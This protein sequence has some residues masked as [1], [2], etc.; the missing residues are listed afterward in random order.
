MVSTN[1]NNKFNKK[2]QDEVLKLTDEDL[3]GLPDLD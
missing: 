1:D 3:D 2:I